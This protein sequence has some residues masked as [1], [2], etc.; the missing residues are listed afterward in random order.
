MKIVKD[1]ELFYAGALTPAN[2]RRLI[3]DAEGN[4]EET[5]VGDQTLFVYRDKRQIWDEERTVLVF[6]S[7]N[8]KQ[9]QLRGIYASIEKKKKALDEL[10]MSLLS[11]KARKRTRKELTDKITNLLK[12]QFLTGVFCWELKKRRNGPYVLD[13]WIDRKKLEEVE[14]SLGI[15]I[16]MTNRHDWDSASIIKSYYGQSA[17]E[18]A[19]KNI[20]NHH[21]LGITPGFHW[22]DQKIHVHFFTGVLGYLLATII[23]KIV[24]EKSN[25]RGSLDSLLETLNSVRLA[26]VLEETGKK[27][28]PRAIHKLEQM[29]K[30]EE[31][32][33]RALGLMELH[34]KPVKLKGVG[35]Y[36]K[37]PPK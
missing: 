30:Q 6:V 32:I 29:S 18:H 34:R 23:W 14:E 9:G 5:R 19:F 26:A 13:Y 20:K 12:G 2:H 8:L 37:V 36:N 21:H 7:R 33:M 10:K 25:F 4:Y 24:K 35:V 22:T 28:R 15:R 1:L 17:V 3:S 16:L 11:P 31:M 27:G